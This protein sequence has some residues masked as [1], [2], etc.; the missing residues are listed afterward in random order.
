MRF[1]SV[2]FVGAG[3]AVGLDTVPVLVAVDVLEAAVGAGFAAGVGFWL[4][5]LAPVA[6]PLVTGLAAGDTGAGLDVGFCGATRV[7]CD[8]SVAVSFAALVVDILEP[9]A[10]VGFSLFSA[11]FAFSFFGL[12]VFGV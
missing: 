2:L 5:V 3:F 1:A 8:V 6:P 10:E 4:T 11:G 12:S 9:L 7:V